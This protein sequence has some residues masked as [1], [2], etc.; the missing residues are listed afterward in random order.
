MS[1]CEN[2]GMERVRASKTRKKGQVTKQNN[3]PGN[4]AVQCRSA[5]GAENA[6]KKKM[7]MQKKE[8]GEGGEKRDEEMRSAAQQQRG[9]LALAGWSFC[10]CKQA[11]KLQQRRRGQRSTVGRREHLFGPLE[12]LKQ[13][14]N[15][16][17]LGAA[18]TS[19]GFPQR[20]LGPCCAAPPPAPGMFWNSDK[21]SADFADHWGA[22][23]KA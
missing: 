20:E 6:T 12:A 16:M 13:L 14:Q 15:K 11:S 19:N 4:A 7:T 2:V 18:C 22:L 5:R 9:G 10:R 1:P 3:V 21:R 17:R 23:S 8:E